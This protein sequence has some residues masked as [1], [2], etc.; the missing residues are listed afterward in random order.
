MAGRQSLLAREALLLSFIEYYRDKFGKDPQIKSINHIAY[1]ISWNVWQMDG[2]KGVV[3]DSCGERVRRNRA[4]SV[5]LK[6]GNRAKA[7][8]KNELTKHNGIY[9]IINDWRATDKTTGKKGKRIRFID[10]INEEA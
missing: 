5:Q 6:D 4:C 8:S 7:V 9:C 1:I 10:L 3:P 2:L